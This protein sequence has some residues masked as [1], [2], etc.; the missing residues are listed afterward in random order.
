[1][2]LNN[3]LVWETAG[4]D[5]HTAALGAIEVDRTPLHELPAGSTPP[6]GSCASSNLSGAG[7]LVN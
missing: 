6:A 2:R 7:M 3:S 5:G 4:A 1:M